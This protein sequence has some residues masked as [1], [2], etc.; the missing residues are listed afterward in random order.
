MARPSST[1]AALGDLDTASVSRLVGAA[2]DL[3]LVLDERGTILEVISPAAELPARELRQWRGRSWVETVTTE[4]R[5]K[6][7]ALLRDAT[8]A[9]DKAI[10]RWR[11]VNHPI[12]GTEDLPVLYSAVRLPAEGKAGRAGSRIVAIGRDLRNVVALQRRLVETQQA[13]ERDYWRFREAET[14]YR[15]LFETSAEAVLIIDGD[16]QRVLEANP[17]ARTLCAGT[18]AKLVGAGV[19]ALFEPSH[20]TRIQDLLA[21]ARSIGRQT[22]AVARLAGGGEVSVA[23]SVFRQEDAALVLMRLAPIVVEPPAPA[24]TGRMARGTKANGAAHSPASAAADPWLTVLQGFID[25]SPEGFV[26]CDAEGRVRRAN[27][28]FATLVQLTS[29]D[30]LRGHTLDRW[31]GRTGVEVGVLIGNLRQRGSVGLFQTSLRGEYGASTDVEVAGSILPEP[32]PG[33]EPVLAFAVRDIERRPRA[34]DGGAGGSATPAIAGAP[35]LQRSAAELAEL[36][37]RTPLKEIVAET[38]DL[39]EQLCIQTAL[40]MTGD[41]RASAAQLLGLSRQSL[42]VK[43]RRYGITD[44]EE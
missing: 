32:L 5:Q 19:A 31:L 23:A 12:A 6:V 38:T 25:T 3:A 34:G 10:A 39:I 27:R 4:S 14:R 18:R 7:E 1:G 43:L 36:V 21:A 35:T 28:A 24:R 33:A 22:P 42:Y 29:E 15:H 11:Q 17:V 37:G 26:F 9:A 20:A 41:N 8:A 30:Q 40:E 44:G 2:S 16:S 13:M